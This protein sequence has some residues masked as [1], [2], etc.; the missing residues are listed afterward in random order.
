MKSY[1]LYFSLMLL[2]S[3]FVLNAQAQHVRVAPETERPDVWTTFI[4]EQLSQ[5]LTSPS[6]EIRIKALEHTIQF[7]RAYGEELDLSQ[8]TPALVSIYNEDE[9]EQCRLAA[10][11]AL[12]AIGDDWGFQ[13][14]RLGIKSQPS[15]HVQHV[16]LAA[17]M[18][19]YGPETFEGATDLAEIAQS[20]KAYFE[21]QR[22][23]QS[24]IAEEQ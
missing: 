1:T 19:H 9:D 15:P 16:T 6:A 13:M 20:V 5:S 3:V 22:S 23:F 14:L 12:H 24:L 21:N 17:L 11:V 10:A 4:G 8:A 2:T 7:A 18:D